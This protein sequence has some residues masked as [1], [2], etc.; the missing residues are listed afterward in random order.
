LICHRGKGINRNKNIVKMQENNENNIDKIIVKPYYTSE[1][2]M[3]MT[4][5]AFISNPS[6]HSKITDKHY[7]LIDDLLPEIVSEI[8]IIIEQQNKIFYSSNDYIRECK[9]WSS[10][11]FIY[12]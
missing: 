7:D 10:Y 5:G 12:Y 11:D 2:E 8:D 9:T 1:Y 3:I 6:I 4:S